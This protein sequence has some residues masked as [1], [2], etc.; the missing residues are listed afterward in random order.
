MQ[1]PV[2]AW[3]MLFGNLFPQQDEDR[4]SIQDT[5]NDRPTSACTRS[6]K[7]PAPGD[8]RDRSAL[9]AALSGAVEEH[10]LAE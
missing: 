6:P 2:Y 3:A 1:S 9:R 4:P 10:P 8:A 7:K 5:H